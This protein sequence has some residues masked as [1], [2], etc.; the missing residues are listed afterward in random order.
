MF[1]SWIAP[2]QKKNRIKYFL[3]YFIIFFGTSLL[4]AINSKRH[5]PLLSI[6]F[7]SFCI[8]LILAFA[9]Y[10]FV[11]FSL[12]RRVT[13]FLNKEENS[14]VLGQSEVLI[15]EEKIIDK[16]TKSTTFYNWDSI[17]R[18]AK[19]ENNFYLYINA[20]YAIIIPKRLLKNPSESKEFEKFILSSIPLSSSFRSIGI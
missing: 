1:T 5:I 6:L 4:A 12:K 10:Q 3:F 7:V 17:I 15:N 8:G 9:L 16:T 11:A 18:F 20:M 2:W 19:S 14:D 13:K